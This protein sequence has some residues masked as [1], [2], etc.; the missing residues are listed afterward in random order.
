MDKKRLQDG[1]KHKI[2][3]QYD[4]LKQRFNKGVR[5][6]QKLRQVKH[7]INQFQNHLRQP[8]I[9]DFEKEELLKQRRQLKNASK[10]RSSN[11]VNAP[12]EEEMKKQPP[13]SKDYVP[14]GQ[15]NSRTDF[16]TKS[17]ILS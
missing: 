8:G 11:R 16:G 3:E 5:E 1:N 14:F 9:E 6:E 13:K 15:Q 4:N 7:K 10:G 2:K 17:A 12:M